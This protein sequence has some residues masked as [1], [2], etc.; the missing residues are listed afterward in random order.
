LARRGRVFP[1]FIRGHVSVRM[2]TGTGQAFLAEKEIRRMPNTE[3]LTQRGLA[4]HGP[5][6]GWC[7]CLTV[8]PAWGSPEMAAS[9]PRAVRW[10]TGIEFERQL[11]TLVAI[12]WSSNPLRQA[13]SKLSRD[14]GV[15]IFLDRRVDPDQDVQFSVQDTALRNMLQGLAEH[16]SLGTCRIG[17]VVYLGPKPTAAVL[18]TVAA[19][20]QE[21]SQSLPTAVRSRILRVKPLQW[22]E[23]SS[24]RQLIEQ[25]AAEVELKIERPEQ[26]PHDLW[27]AV[28]LPPLDFAQRLSLLLAGLELTFEYSDA[29]A[30]RLLPLP[31]TA[32]V[33]RSYAVSSQQNAA[34]QEMTQRF[35]ETRVTRQAG[36]VIVVAPLEAHELLQ[37]LL[38]GRRSP[39]ATPAKPAA[40]PKVVWTLRIE[41]QSVGA[42]A[43][44]VAT[45]LECQLEYD[46]GLRSKLKQLVSFE[47]NQVT[48]EKL[49]E[50]ALSPAG[51]TYHLDATTLRIL[52]ADSP[53]Q[54]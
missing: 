26:I 2:F 53:P 28:E 5:W 30:I 22:P 6:L 29:H 27:P 43:K 11:D 10:K 7:F 4:G 23:R 51:L 1:D 19:Q 18:R 44:T 37:G 14:H 34:L 39:G 33:E 32:T 21:L 13:L 3:S 12:T 46:P 25:L 16:L 38:H 48:L 49:L 41:N 35:P 15:V 45:R 50:T 9:E 40:K 36:N 8:C 47:V 31:A 52:P 24:P 42:V 17:S 54:P 20:T